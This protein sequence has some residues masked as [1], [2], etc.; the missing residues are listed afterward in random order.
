MVGVSSVE[1]IGTPIS[2]H[3]TDLDGEA[4]LTQRPG[5][6]VR[7]LVTS[8]VITA[9]PEPLTAVIAHDLTERIRFEERLEYQAT[10]DAL[11][12]L[13][14]R[15]A[16]LEHIT[17]CEDDVAQRLSAGVRP[18]DFIGR[19]GGDEFVVVVHD[20]DGF[21]GLVA[22]GRDL[23]ERIEFPNF[24]D[25]T[26]SFSLSASVGV[27]VFDGAPSR[28]GLSA[29]DA[30][31]QADAAVYVAKDRGRARVEVFD[32]ELQQTLVTGPTSRSHS[33]PPSPTANSSSTSNPSW[34]SRPG[35]SR[36]PRP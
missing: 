31:R 20:H 9:G 28:L 26:T 11:T 22:D 8:S 4:S 15:F 14:N 6:H 36:V 34:I 16:L 35:S 23:I 21:E 33:A 1:Q 18:A 2:Q 13:P 5:S 24:G 7:C 10:H 12:T 17:S 3:L 27:A 32:Q 25:E 30:I 29:L 19:L